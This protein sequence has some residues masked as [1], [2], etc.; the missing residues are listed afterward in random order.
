MAK[1]KVLLNRIRAFAVTVA[2]R[3]L[4]THAASSAFYSFLSLF[5]MVVLAASLLP[6]VGIS[7]AALVYLVHRIAPD[8]VTELIRVILDNVYTNVFPALP[9]SLL[10]LLYSSAQAFSELLKGMAAMVGAPRPASFL[11]RRLRAILL[12]MAL[13]ITLLLSLAVLVF[14][15]KVVL[16]MGLLHPRLAHLLRLVLWLRYAIMAVL[17]W[18]LFTLLYRSVPGRRLSFRDV[19]GSAALVAGAWIVFSALFSLYASRFLDLTLYGSMAAMALTMLWLYY[20]QHILLVGAAL[21]AR[22]QEA[23]SLKTAS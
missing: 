3:G 14:G 23:V 13:L 2:D 18:L 12:T 7:E 22:K 20:C 1:R 19:R 5:P 17:L 16:W 15:G 21:C 10:G 8:S 4:A 11:K 6:C 9:L